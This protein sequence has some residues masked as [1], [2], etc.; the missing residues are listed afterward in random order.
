MEFN[1]CPTEGTGTNITSALRTDNFGQSWSSEAGN[2]CKSH[3]LCLSLAQK[4]VKRPT[5]CTFQRSGLHYFLPAFHPSAILIQLSFC[6]GGWSS[7]R[8]PGSQLLEV[9]CPCR[10]VNPAVPGSP[11]LRGVCAVWRR[12]ALSS[13]PGTRSSSLFTAL[14]LLFGSGGSTEFPNSW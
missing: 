9:A 10:C 2:G 4:N 8:D 1:L 6:G 7:P 5:F 3:C 14:R 12:A 13:V 11:G